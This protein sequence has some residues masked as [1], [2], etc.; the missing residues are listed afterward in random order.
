MAQR[1]LLVVEVHLLVDGFAGWNV[2]RQNHDSR[3]ALLQ[4]S[5]VENIHRRRTR[6]LDGDVSNFSCIAVHLQ[7][8]F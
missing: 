6:L 3:L 2:G 7:F 5:Q 8:C 1:L 4:N